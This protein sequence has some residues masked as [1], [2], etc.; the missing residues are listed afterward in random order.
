MDYAFCATAWGWVAVAGTRAGAVVAILPQPSRDAALAALSW[1]TA[2][3]GHALEDEASYFDPLLQQ[4]EGYFAGREVEF[5]FPVDLAGLAAFQRQVLQ[6]VA[7]IPYG[8]VRS[9]RWVAESIHHSRAYRAVGQ[10]LHCN[11]LPVIIPCH[12]VVGSHG[13]PGGYAWGIDIKQRL[14]DWE[15]RVTAQGTEASDSKN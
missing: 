14:L 15:M 10:A 11:P 5:S 12:R 4:L 7:L 3:L 1:Q 2:A 13:E 9:Y 8:Q 6:A